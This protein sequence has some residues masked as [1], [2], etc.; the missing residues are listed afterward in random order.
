[1]AQTM[2]HPPA[3]PP[4]FRCADCAYATNF[5]AGA[6]AHSKETGH[7]VAGE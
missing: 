3:P 4:R 7:F 2:S 1:M 5:E 6:S